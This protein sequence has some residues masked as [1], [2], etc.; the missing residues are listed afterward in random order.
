MTFFPTCIRTPSVAGESEAIFKLE[1]GGDSMPVS[2]LGTKVR[3]IHGF[4]LILSVTL[5]SFPVPCVKI[6]YTNEFELDC[7]RKC[8]DGYLYLK[9]LVSIAS[10]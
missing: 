10:S 7:S 9:N 1:M 4:L 8:S 3:D 2:V 5:V 6:L